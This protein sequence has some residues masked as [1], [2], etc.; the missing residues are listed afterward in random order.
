MSAPE[1][2]HAIPSRL[3][4]AILAV[5]VVLV[6]TLLAAAR[7]ARG[8]TLVALA[9]V[10]GVVM[11][12]V[13]SILHEAEHGMLFESRRI[14]DAAGV[15][16]ALLFPAP[17]HLL[18]QGHLGHHMR[19]RSDDEAFDLYFDG[20]PPIWKWIQLY[21]ILTGFYWLVVAASNVLV[22]VAGAL[23]SR[24]LVAFDRPTAAFLAAFNAR[25]LRVIRAEAL[26]AVLLHASLV[27]L[28]GVPLERYFAVYLGFGVS[29]SALQYVHHF[30]T[31]RHVTR[32]ARD[33]RILEPLDRLWLNHNWHRVHHENP[34]VPW[35]HLPALGR[36]AG[37]ERGFL[38]WAYLRMWAGPRYT[39]EHVEN[40]FAGRI[41]H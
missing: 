38:P 6:V 23:P 41:I 26:G 29:W 24:R 2:R 13:Y 22:L 4:A 15:A 18:R 10:F 27:V 32:G 20:E 21:G 40:A 11:N 7:D 5:Q 16:V 35:I 25:D 1:R 17:F 39:T 12:S 28:L 37:H 34:T 31:E 3:N 9:I 19:N 8:S 33:L 30:G 14:N 36:A